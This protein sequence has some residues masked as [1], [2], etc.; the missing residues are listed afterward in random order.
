[1][2]RP[3]FG[4]IIER[5]VCAKLIERKTAGDDAPKRSA[6]IARVVYLTTSPVANLGPT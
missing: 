5:L 4:L 1:L 3:T 2:R 6:V